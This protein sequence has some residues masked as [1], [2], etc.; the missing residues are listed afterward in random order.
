MKKNLSNRSIT[1]E[2]C[3]TESPTL[4]SFH[5]DFPEPG[6]FAR[7]RKQG[8]GIRTSDGTFEFVESKREGSHAEIIKKLSHGRLTKTLAGEF[9]LTIRIPEWEHRPTSV[10]ADNALVAMDALQQ[11]IYEEEAA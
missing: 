7:Y 11:Y 2:G 3:F 9:L 1:G 8:T 5:P 6:R 4:F 10:I